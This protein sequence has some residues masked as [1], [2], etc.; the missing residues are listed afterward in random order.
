MKAG[1]L[2]RKAAERIA[3]HG[4]MRGSH[5]DEKRGMCVRA[6]F[7]HAYGMTTEQWATY[8]GPVNKSC[9][10]FGKWLLAN[11]DTDDSPAWHANGWNDG[12]MT[13]E[14]FYKFPPPKSAEEVVAVLNKF[15]D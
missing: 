3:T 7:A 15:A 14:D 10:I 9:Q 13:D 4:W 6:A 1:R 2:A 8:D 12:A 5:G 11:K